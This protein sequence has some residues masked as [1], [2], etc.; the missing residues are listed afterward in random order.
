MT[1]L[2][3]N[4][5][6]GEPFD[7]LARGLFEKLANELGKVRSDFLKTAYC[8]ARPNL[9]VIIRQRRNRFGRQTIATLPAPPHSYDSR[10]AADWLASSSSALS[11]RLLTSSAEECLGR[12]R[13]KDTDR[14]S[15]RLAG[16]PF[17]VNA[18]A[19]PQVRDLWR[20]R[21]PAELLVRDVALQARAGALACRSL[22]VRC[23][24]PSRAFDLT[25]HT[26]Q[27]GSPLFMGGRNSP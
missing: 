15:V 11:G 8:A 1:A 13:T 20:L 26:F 23:V 2:F 5:R 27:V 25:P 21:V 17:G 10:L 9:G 12:A 14:R 24:P 7:E 16:A 4:Y 3:G 19:D 18:D 22:R 6:Q